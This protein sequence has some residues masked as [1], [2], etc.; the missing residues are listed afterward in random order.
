MYGLIDVV[1]SIC[2]SFC[3][4]SC[5]GLYGGLL[6]DCLFIGVDSTYCILLNG[7][8]HKSIGLCGVE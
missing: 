1:N 2:I 7:F 8:C 4:L 3:V 6:A 5:I